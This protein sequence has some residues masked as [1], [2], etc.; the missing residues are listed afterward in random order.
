MSGH[1]KWSTIKRAKAVTDARRSAVFT[2]LAKAVMVAARL[3]GADPSMNFRLRLA[4][5]KAREGNMPNDNIDRAIKKGAGGGEG[6]TLQECVYEGIGHDGVG[7]IVQVLTDNRNRATSE[8]K[9]ILVKN[10]A[11]FG[12][13]NSVLWQFDHKGVI[14]IA[15]E[16][17]ASLPESQQLALIDAGA[18][19]IKEEP[20]GWTV[21]CPKESLQHVIDA[22]AKNNIPCASQGLEYVP[23]NLVPTTHAGQI[24][25]CLE[26]LESHDDIESVYTNA[27]F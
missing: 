14:R 4:I 11:T 2:K 15:K 12:A 26:E 27:D 18:E 13:T 25:K 10:G 9:N 21:I 19:D 8:V 16:S 7:I 24:Q 17:H 6:V 1:S 20:E 5:Q 22:A 23:K 3:G